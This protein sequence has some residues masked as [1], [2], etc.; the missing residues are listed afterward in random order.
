MEMSPDTKEENV[1]SELYLQ[2]GLSNGNLLRTAVDF[3]TGNL[4]DTRTR[5]LGSKGV[6]LFKVQVNNKPA[7]L[8]LS[9]RP[10]I[11]YTFTSQYFTVPLSYESIDFAA[12]FCS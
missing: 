12:G 4:S 10:W 2:V 1:N 9:S 5:F 3:V 11:C 7:M 8:A 6:K